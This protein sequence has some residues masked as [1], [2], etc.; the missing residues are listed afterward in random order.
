M[1]RGVPRR[2][3]A[4][5][6]DYAPAPLAMTLATLGIDA[7][8][9]TTL[10]AHADAGRLGHEVAMS[11]FFRRLPRAR[12]FIV[13]AGLRAVLDHAAQMRFDE[14]EL[15]A[16]AAHP[17]LGPALAAHPAVVGA[18]RAVDGFEGDIDAIPEGTLA[19][20]SPGVR[21]DGSPLVVAG[22][23]LQPLLSA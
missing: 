9:L 8:Q 1:M 2:T 20:A 22:A 13:F 14:A 19:Y 3:C 18:M 12:N 23:P 21:T 17:L 11:F 4:C 6:L 16:L 15:R 5:D 7:Y 10:V